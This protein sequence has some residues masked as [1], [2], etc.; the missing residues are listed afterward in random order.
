MVCVLQRSQAG[1]LRGIYSPVTLARGSRS[2][3]L[4]ASVASTLHDVL[5]SAKDG[6]RTAKQ[7]ARVELLAGAVSAVVLQ[8]RYIITIST[9]SC[10]QNITPL[11]TTSGRG[12]P[13][14][15]SDQMDGWIPHSP[16]AVVRCAR[17][18]QLDRS[19]NVC[20][21][22]RCWRSQLQVNALLSRALATAVRGL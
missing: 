5:K 14:N 16:Q 21:R 18:S 9:R 19:R 4:M 11:A 2:W 7:A 6:L 17:S 8:L 22:K 13:L 20:R 15:E 12:V 3:S 1:P 10:E